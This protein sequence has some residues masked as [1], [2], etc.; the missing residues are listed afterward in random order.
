MSFLGFLSLLAF[1][2][3][4]SLLRVF[5]GF[6]FFPLSL[7]L[8]LSRF[9]SSF[10]FLLP[11]VGFSVVYLV[12]VLNDIFSLLACYFRVPGFLLGFAP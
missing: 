7:S 11:S 8:S 6:R 2:I 10:C 9:V 3:A 5:V 12:F 1:W 4:V